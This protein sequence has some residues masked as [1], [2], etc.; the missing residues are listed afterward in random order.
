MERDDFKNPLYVCW[1]YGEIKKAAKGDDQN[2][3]DTQRCH[4]IYVAN[5]V[6]GV[7]VAGRR[8]W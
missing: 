7:H 8:T 4:E 3:T 2:H 6:P 1:N 5:K